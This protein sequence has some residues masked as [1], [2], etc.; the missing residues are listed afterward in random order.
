MMNQIG[1][2][3]CS[4]Y[5]KPLGNAGKYHTSEDTK[6]ILLE[7]NAAIQFNKHCKLYNLTSHYIQIIINGFSF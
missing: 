1:V 6:Q 5:G 3:W 7:F 4:L 2:G